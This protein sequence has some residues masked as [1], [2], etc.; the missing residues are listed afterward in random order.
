MPTGSRDAPR[1]GCA[2]V[3]VGTLPTSSGGVRIFAASVYLLVHFDAASGVPVVCECG[4]SG[5]PVLYD[6]VGDETDNRPCDKAHRD[7][8]CY[9]DA[10]VYNQVGKV[11][12]HWAYLAV[13]APCCRCGRFWLYECCFLMT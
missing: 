6:A 13:Y 7:D 3:S 5:T 12:S 11:I 1:T 8:Y 4:L 2:G 9:E 10:Y